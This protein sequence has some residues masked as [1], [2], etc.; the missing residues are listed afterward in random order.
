MRKSAVIF[1][2]DSEEKFVMFFSSKI[3]SDRMKHFSVCILIS[4]ILRT[5]CVNCQ[6]TAWP[7]KYHQTKIPVIIDTDIGTDIDDTWAIA[8]LLNRPEV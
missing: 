8:Y 7:N 4:L 5:L 2:F 6:D 1:G 3:R